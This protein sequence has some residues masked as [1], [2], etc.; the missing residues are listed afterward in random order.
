MNNS[1]LTTAINKIIKEELKHYDKRLGLINKDSNYM[2]A[3]G[4]S[5]GRSMEDGYS[6]HAMVGGGQERSQN[7]IDDNNIDAQKLIAYIKQNIRTN[8]AIRYDVRDYISG[9]PGTVGGQK[10][11]RD[12]FIKQ[13]SQPMK[14]TSEGITYLKNIIKE[15]LKHYDKAQF[16]NIG[17]SKA[18][19]V[20]KDKMAEEI[21]VDDKKA[22]FLED[23][24]N[25]VIEYNTT[26]LR[27]NPDEFLKKLMEIGKYVKAK[28][29]VIMVNLANHTYGRKVYAYDVAKMLQDCEGRKGKSE[30]YEVP[31][32]D[33][34]GDPEK[35]KEVK[36]A[37][38]EKS[39]VKTSMG[40]SE[41]ASGKPKGV[42]VMKEGLASRIISRL[43]GIGSTDVDKANIKLKGICA[44]IEKALAVAV[45]DLEKLFTLSGTPSEVTEAVTKYQAMLQAMRAFNAKVIKGDFIDIT[46]ISSTVDANYK[47]K[48]EKEKAKLKAL[49]GANKKAQAPV[50][51]TTTPA[52]A[53]TQ[54]DPAQGELVAG[55]TQISKK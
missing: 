6:I 16:K 27:D 54:V 29:D 20:E 51:T 31:S 15:E 37:S 53:G 23:I 55:K 34:K 28:K 10:H 17:K 49:K 41:K 38:L 1:I 44:N 47:K 25:L 30:T 21:K 11:L 52:T 3:D 42:K 9:A 45:I 22:K 5:E 2:P 8:P 26:K 40:D 43:S 24:N 48:Y 13:F 7:F 32:A 14:M 19:K 4:L 46:K 18:D 39:N 36:E 35:A 50:T 12:K 33:K